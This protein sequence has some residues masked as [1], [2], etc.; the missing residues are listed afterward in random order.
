M[1]DRHQKGPQGELR[2]LDTRQHARMAVVEQAVEAE[3]RHQESGANA[4][5]AAMIGDGRE[6]RE[7]QQHHRHG[8]KMASRQR[9][10]GSEHCAPAFLR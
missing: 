7:G 6:Q 9:H 5:A 3:S 10:E 4:D 2:R 1:G 8:G